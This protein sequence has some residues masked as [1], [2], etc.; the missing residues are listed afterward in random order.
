M[1]RVYF[2]SAKIQ[3]RD[4]LL[5]ILAIA[6]ITVSIVCRVAAY[7]NT[8]ASAVSWKVANRVIVIDPGHGGMDPGAV[9]KAGTLEKDVVLEVAHKLKR[10]LSDAG[11]IV[12]LTRESDSDLSGKAAGSAYEKKR[13]D[14]A[15]RVAIAN[16]NKA[17]IYVSLHLNSFPSA[18]WTGAQTFYQHGSA[19]AKLLAECVQAEIIK[20]LKN[21]DRQP[22]AEN[23]Y[24]T[25][26]TAMPA[27]TVELGFL[28]NPREEQLLRQADYQDK[29]AVAIFSGIAKYFAE[30]DNMGRKK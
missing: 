15:N 17:D 19:K 8:V 30:A 7:E 28:S 10:L 20:S 9:G 12:I 21:T 1:K 22:L 3:K 13:R 25:R 6:I 11:A 29:M 24:T 16:K 27:V 23:F 5:A 2:W 14:L 26:Q 4:L 18:R